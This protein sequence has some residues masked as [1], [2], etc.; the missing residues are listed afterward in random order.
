MTTCAKTAIAPPSQPLQNTP[1]RGFAV[2]VQRARRTYFRNSNPR[3]HSILHVVWYDSF[4][5]ERLTGL[6]VSFAHGKLHRQCE[7]PTAHSESLLTSLNSDS[8]ALQVTTSAA[9][10]STCQASPKLLYKST[11]VVQQVVW[12]NRD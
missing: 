5:R 7:N 11:V 4:I 6:A 12:M 2:V 3:L 1:V 8:L 9:S 10:N